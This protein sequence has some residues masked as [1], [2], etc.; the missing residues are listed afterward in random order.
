MSDEKLQGLDAD[1]LIGRVTQFIRTDFGGETHKERIAL[2]RAVEADSAVGAVLTKLTPEE[3]KVLG[4]A[5]VKVAVHAC[6]GSHASPRAS[7]SPAPF[8]NCAAVSE[9][10]LP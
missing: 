3:Q 1:T 10:R 2:Q 5:M 7:V 8:K 9:L 4:A 6:E